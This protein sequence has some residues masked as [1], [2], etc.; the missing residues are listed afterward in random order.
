MHCMVC[1]TSWMLRS[2]EII[3]AEATDKSIRATANGYLRR[4]ED[5]DFYFA[6]QLSCRLFELT[7][8]LSKQ[9]QGESVCVGE[10]IQL[11]NHAINELSD[12]RA[13]D[14]FSA[15]WD[16]TEKL[17]Q[18]H[19]ANEAKLPRLVRAPRRVQETEP[20]HFES[21]K[22]FFKVKYMEVFDYAIASLQERIT[23]KAMGVLDSMEQLLRFGWNGKVT[24][25]FH[26]EQVCNHYKADWD[27]TQLHGGSVTGY[28]TFT[29]YRTV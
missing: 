28:E 11:V 13:D 3:E 4:L 29:F 24:S 17:R 20:H 7:D 18:K 21:S 5:F 15:V 1:A 10:G 9:L 22:D 12:L 25:L 6:L 16:E 27:S 26:L 19:A 23:N 8:R 14:M 2:L